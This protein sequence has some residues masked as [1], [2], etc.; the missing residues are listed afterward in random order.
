MQRLFCSV[1]ECAWRGSPSWQAVDAFRVMLQCGCRINSISIAIK[2]VLRAWNGL[3]D[4]C[5]YRL[6]HAEDN[7]VFTIL[8]LSVDF[9]GVPITFY[10]GLVARAS[11]RRI[12]NW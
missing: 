6:R 4:I 3:R 8:G 2:V 11:D 5:V 9:P 12:S 10:N 7:V 1:V